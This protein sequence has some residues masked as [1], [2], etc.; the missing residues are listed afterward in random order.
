MNEPTPIPM[1]IWCP[2]CHHRHI[3]EGE[4]K[5]KIHH[6]HSC[7]KCG[8]TFRLAIVPT[9][10]VLFLPGF[11]TETKAERKEAFLKMAREAGELLNDPDC[12]SL[13][14]GHPDEGRAGLEELSDD[15]IHGVN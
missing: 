15:D 3:D 1:L 13:L 4:F 6:T 2:L 10:G 5:T 12:P 8:L 9:V 11:K 7:Q 14:A